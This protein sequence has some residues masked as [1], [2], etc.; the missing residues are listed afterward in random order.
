MACKTHQSFLLLLDFCFTSF[1]YF[2]EKIRLVG[3][4][5][6][7]EPKKAAGWHSLNQKQLAPKKNINVWIIW[8]FPTFFCCFFRSFFV[9][10]IFV[11]KKKPIGCLEPSPEW[12]GSLVEPAMKLHTKQVGKKPIDLS[13]FSWDWYLWNSLAFKRSCNCLK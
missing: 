11:T 5:F 13:S 10:V 2:V 1:I 6:F 8:K 4:R 7:T 12:G 3:G 9:V